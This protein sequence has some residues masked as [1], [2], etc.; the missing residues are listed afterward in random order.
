M[1]TKVLG[2]QGESVAVKFLKDKKFKI[3]KQNYTTKIGEIDI[4]AQTKDIIVFVEV[5][6]RKSIRFG[7]PRE[8]IN[9]TK[10]KKIR[11][12]ATQYL[13]ANKLMNCKVRFD[14]IEVL[15]DQITHI[16]NCF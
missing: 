10:Q 8:A 13:L 11:K 6:A 16:E 5:K 2:T 9:L 1:N 14:C 15:G 4:I 7:Y 3:L 12:V